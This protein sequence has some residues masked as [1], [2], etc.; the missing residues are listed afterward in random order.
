LEI[1]KNIAKFLVDLDKLSRRHGIW[2]EK[3]GKLVNDELKVVAD[4]LYIN[5]S[6]QEY[7]ARGIK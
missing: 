3:D 6:N 1:D 7:F 4:S 5:E 2:I